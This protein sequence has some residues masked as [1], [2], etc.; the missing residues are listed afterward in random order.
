MSDCY[1]DN[2]A[3]D[4]KREKLDQQ[5][6]YSASAV[7]LERLQEHHDFSVPDRRAEFPEPVVS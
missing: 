5:A 1:R 7:L 2:P 3:N 6:I 4:A